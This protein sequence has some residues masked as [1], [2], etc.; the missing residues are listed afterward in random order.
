MRSTKNHICINTNN[1]EEAKI[2]INICKNNKIIPI[3]FIKSYLIDGFGPDWLIEFRIMLL[4]YYKKNM[5][6]FYIDCKKNYALFINLVTQ[7]FEYLKVKG[8]KKTLIRLAQIAKKNKIGMNPKFNVV[9]LKNINNK[10][11]IIE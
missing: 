6:K 5:F 8:D 1:I 9:D 4:D 2:I 7:K 3:L 10:I 11:K